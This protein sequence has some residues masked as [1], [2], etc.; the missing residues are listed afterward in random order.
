MPRFR[1][2]MMGAAF[3]YLAL[4]GLAITLVPKYPLVAAVFVVFG[5]HSV[6]APLGQRPSK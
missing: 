5:V 3:V 1:H 4:A 2:F 6:V